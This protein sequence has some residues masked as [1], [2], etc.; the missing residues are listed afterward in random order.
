MGFGMDRSVDKARRGK[1]KC[2]DG[3]D[4]LIFSFWGWRFLWC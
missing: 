3:V 4:V 1:E 2:G